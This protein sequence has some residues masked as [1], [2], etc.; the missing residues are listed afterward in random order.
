MLDRDVPESPWQHH[1][2]TNRL[3][4]PPD[5]FSSAQ[6]SSELDFEEV[7]RDEVFYL[8]NDD[9]DEVSESVDYFTE[10]RQNTIKRVVK[11]RQSQPAVS[12]NGLAL[13]SGFSDR[14]FVCIHPYEPSHPLG[15][16]LDY[17]DVV[18][19]YILRHERNVAHVF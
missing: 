14:K 15:L 10:E 4:L 16:W 8:A 11:Q 12:F 3:S 17:G 1:K 13:E 6:S 9:D 5:A 2:L 7:E 19:G 18:Q